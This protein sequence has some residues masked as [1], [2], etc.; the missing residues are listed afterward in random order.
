MSGE[1]FKDYYEQ[2]IVKFQ[3]KFPLHTDVI[4]NADQVDDFMYEVED[5]CEDI[6]GWLPMW[7]RIQKSKAYIY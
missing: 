1:N 3:E 5:Y 7:E 6:G 2:E 4:Y